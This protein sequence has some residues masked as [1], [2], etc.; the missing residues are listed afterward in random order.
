MLQS[1][2]QKT[3]QM[4]NHHANIRT[5]KPSQKTILTR[6]ASFAGNHYLAARGDA[7]HYAHERA[8]EEEEILRMPEREAQEVREIFQTYGLSDEESATVVESLRK[9]PNDWVAL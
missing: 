5:L 2:T 9:R 8:R 7:E 3:L 4:F 1:Q 6:V